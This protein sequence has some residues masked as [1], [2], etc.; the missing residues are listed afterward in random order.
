MKSSSVILVLVGMISTLSSIDGAKK[1]DVQAEINKMTSKFDQLE[2]P[3]PAMVNSVMEQI[4]E[5]CRTNRTI[6]EENLA[7]S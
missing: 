1:I 3:S 5:S 4:K 6:D 2:K 7:V